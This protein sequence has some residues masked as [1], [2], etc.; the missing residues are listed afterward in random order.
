MSH[1]DVTY[2]AVEKACAA[3]IGQGVRPTVRAV[4]ERLG[5]SNSTLVRHLRSWNEARATLERQ[6][7]DLPAELLTTLRRCISAAEDAARAGAQE[8]VAAAQQTVDDLLRDN[9][10]LGGRLADSDAALA[11]VR[12]ERDSARGQFEA[13]G[14]ER[15]AARRELEGLQASTLALQAELTRA[16]ARLDGSQ[17]ALVE[18][19]A[20]EADARQE[21]ER[22]RRERNDVADRLKAEE[23]GTAGLNAQLA[24]E[25]AA[26]AQ[27]QGALQAAQASLEEQRPMACRVA[28]AEATAAELRSTVEMLQRLLPSG[29]KEAAESRPSRRSSKADGASAG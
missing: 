13:V 24:A 1:Q 28:A 3:I 27:V 23:V 16:V 14:A 18:S 12:S 8:Q 29:A 26:H 5:G 7:Q 9:E 20:R 6:P 2:E 21:A 11:A 25:R 10:E 4:R 15:E 17:A 19:R 22:A